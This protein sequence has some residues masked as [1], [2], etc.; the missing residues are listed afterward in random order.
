MVIIFSIQ[1]FAD[2]LYTELLMCVCVCVCVC[3]VLEV[4]LQKKLVL[5]MELHLVKKAS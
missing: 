3:R 5:L 2:L 1:Y 4:E